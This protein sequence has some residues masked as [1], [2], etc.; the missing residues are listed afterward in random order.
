VARLFNIAT[1]EYMEVP[2]DQVQQHVA[3]GQFSFADGTMVAIEIPGGE[4][5]E[6][7][8]RYARKALDLGARY[9]PFEEAKQDRLKEK[10]GK[11]WGN[12]LLAFGVGTAAGL[13]MTASNV[14][15]VKSGILSKETLDALRDYQTGAYY[16]GD[17]LGILGTG[18]IGALG[19]GA[20][21]GSTLALAGK[22]A[23]NTPAMVTA[24]GASKA[25]SALAELATRGATGLGGKYAGVGIKHFAEGAID[26]AAYAG[27]EQLSEA[28]LGNPEVTAETF[29]GSIGLAG[30]LGGGLGAA[31]P[32]MYAAS[33]PAREKIAEKVI[34]SY[35]T[36][37]GG[38]TTNPS[39]LRKKVAEVL[40][41]QYGMSMD[42][43]LKQLELT[44]EGTLRRRDIDRAAIQM[45]IDHTNLENQV[46]RIQQDIADLNTEMELGL[47]E[48]GPV[49]DMLEQR[50]RDLIEK[51]EKHND[52]TAEVERVQTLKN[53]QKDIKEKYKDKLAEL[54]QQ[55]D[56]MRDAERQSRDQL[57]RLRDTLKEEGV[58]HKDNFMHDLDVNAE[59][60]EAAVRELYELVESGRAL[61]RGANRN[62]NL[63]QQ[64]ESGTADDD[65]ASK[66]IEDFADILVTV[67]NAVNNPP[68][69]VTRREGEIKAVLDILE[70]FESDVVTAV[71]RVGKFKTV[72]RETP[73]TDAD[74]QAAYDGLEQAAA[75]GHKI[76]LKEF[77]RT[78]V[79]AGVQNT[80]DLDKR[81]K[82]ELFVAFENTRKSLGD[83]V[84]GRNAE[85]AIAWNTKSALKDA[86]LQM[87]I[88][89]EHKAFGKAGENIAN[90]NQAF[91]RFLEVDNEFAKLYLTPGKKARSIHPDRVP[92]FFRTA[93]N[94]NYRRKVL[95]EYQAAAGQLMAAAAK[96]DLLDDKEVVKQFNE[97]SSRISKAVDESIDIQR[98]TKFIGQ[99]S[100]GRTLR[101]AEHPVHES[102]DALRQLSTSKAKAGDVLETD[103]AGVEI[104]K[105]ELEEQQAKF[106][107][108]LR[109]KEAELFAAEKELQ[110]ATTTREELVS[111]SRDELAGVN[112]DL[113]QIQARE[114]SLRREV[115]RLQGLQE[116]SINELKNAQL[117]MPKERNITPYR[118]IL[119]SSRE[120]QIANLQASGTSS[121]PGMV[122]F[123]FGG[124]QGAAL[125]TLGFGHLIKSLRHAAEPERRFMMLMDAHDMM[126]EYQRNRKETLTAFVN[127]KLKRAIEDKRPSPFKLVMGSLAQAG[128]F[129]A[130]FAP[131]SDDDYIQATERISAIEANPELKTKIIE[132]V[133]APIV[134]DMPETAQAVQMQVSKTLS[135]IESKTPKPPQNQMMTLAKREWRPSDAAVAKTARSIDVAYN[136]FAPLQE[137]LANYTLVGDEVEAAK[138]CHPHLYQSCCEDM[139][140]AFSELTTPPSYD[141]RNVAATFLG[142]QVEPT[143]QGA[144]VMGMQAMFS[145]EQETV[146]S[147]PSAASTRGRSEAALTPSQERQTRIV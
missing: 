51:I 60:G 13:S 143:R 77:A 78:E 118:P 10:Y 105:E 134:Q 74:Y 102:I 144:F 59:K 16:S 6:I 7:E 3:S 43:A 20:A 80:P 141:I 49:L 142:S 12:A 45:V 138:V 128:N 89:Q 14:A 72:A 34:S 28:I 68:P 40:V 119:P 15:L 145:Q 87:K 71:S 8:S 124:W 104:A 27:A 55:L 44:P 84:F 110:R 26:A 69:G 47:S 50:Q 30:L 94:Q 112:K 1:N 4:K 41:D 113:E 42:D 91:N 129:G 54:N 132:D 133:V 48:N 123:Y 18:G 32:G 75:S 5:F 37:S 122:G 108:E 96:A 79:R 35:A 95:E 70:Q 106:A 107:S 38:T 21:K 23:R 98:Q 127:G 64:I 86:W 103:K 109:A 97:I 46:Q 92:Q 115:A 58:Y 62:D 33:L 135:F 111:G 11:G 67:R 120:G 9:V 17:V 52:T 82:Q 22:I 136:G 125:S 117:E 39:R 19:R 24:K 53:E 56:N 81:I 85:G 76:D 88:L 2:E 93:D 63:V 100:G 99:I 29:V 137:S 139:L 66:V 147:D 114:K 140:I 57:N 130:I 65:T 25:G 83:K 90:I 126:R 131:G 31:L 116:R 61:S 146:T 36:I 73:T 101:P 121:A